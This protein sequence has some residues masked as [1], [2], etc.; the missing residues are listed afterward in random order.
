[1]LA[2][3]FRVDYGVVDDG[4]ARLIYLGN[5]RLATMGWAGAVRTPLP[6]QH[7]YRRDAQER[8]GSRVSLRTAWSIS[9]SLRAWARTSSRGSAHHSRGPQHCEGQDETAEVP[10]GVIKQRMGRSQ[11]A[12]TMDLYA[13]HMEESA[14]RP[15]PRRARFWRSLMQGEGGL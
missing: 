4:D 15:L 13:A 1:M 11:I 7:R 3:G 8:K 14:D 10:M 2:N 12:M 6:R 5:E 9:T